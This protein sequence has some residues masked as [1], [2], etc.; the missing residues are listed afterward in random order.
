MTSLSANV[1]AGC[2]SSV[3]FTIPPTVLGIGIGCFASCET[4]ET[5]TY[6]GDIEVTNLLSEN[7]PVPREVV[8]KEDYFYDQFGGFPLGSS[9]SESVSSDSSDADNCID[10]PSGG[11][12]LPPVAIA[13]II[14]AV[15]AV[16][17]IV[18][19]SF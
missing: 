9:G 3:T 1:F 13:G 5:V 2:A 18:D 14:I 10:D 7:C 16:V 15:L 8:V 17:A 4:P 6:L 12:G 19:V 11:D